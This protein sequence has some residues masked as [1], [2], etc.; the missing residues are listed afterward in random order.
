M[1]GQTVA[2][3]I[4]RN[5]AHARGGKRVDLVDPADRGRAEACEQD[6]RLLSAPVFKIGELDAVVREDGLFFDL[7]DNPPQ[8][9]QN[10]KPTATLAARMEVMAATK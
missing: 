3:A 2:A 10:M 1:L 9:D 7:H 8:R 5:G 4:E 6:D